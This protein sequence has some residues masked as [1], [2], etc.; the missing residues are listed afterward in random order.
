MHTRN[1][2]LDELKEELHNR[3]GHI[4]DLFSWPNNTR[5]S[6]A[7]R[8]IY[9][10]DYHEALAYTQFLVNTHISYFDIIKLVPHNYTI[11]LN[12]LE[13]QEYTHSMQNFVIA[14]EIAH[15][16]QME[17]RATSLITIKL[18][19]LPYSAG[20][21]F[22]LALASFIEATY[23]TELFFIWFSIAL[24][25]NSLVRSYELQADREA[26]TALGSVQG[27]IDFMHAYATQHKL[28]ISPWTN[29]FIYYLFATHPTPEQRTQ[30]LI[31]FTKTKNS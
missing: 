20:L 21:G 8:S 16:L 4:L 3:V 5:P 27:G 23:A 26:A 15:V 6:I 9:D 31:Y 2:Q 10:T 28:L 17:Q 24:V 14:H 19:S 12:Y 30:S 13:L 1:N 7:L 29:F 25:C 11:T 22:A 18:L